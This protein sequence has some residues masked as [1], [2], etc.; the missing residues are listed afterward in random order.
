MQTSPEINE[1]AKALAK[2]QGEFP[3]IPKEKKVEV[4]SKPPERKFLYAYYYAELSTI[5]SHIKSVMAANGLS[6]VQGIVEN[7][8]GMACVTKLIHSSGQYFETTTPMILP[9][10]FDM[11]GLAGALT[12]ARRYAVMAI[13]GISPESDDDS[14]GS[15]DKEAVIMDKPRPMKTQEPTKEGPASKA[16]IVALYTACKGKGLNEAKLKEL[17]KEKFGTDDVYKITRSQVLTL[18]TFVQT[19]NQ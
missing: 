11:Q 10:K 16:E 7:P 2:A 13:L 9:E 3:E 5:F 8:Q 19:K 14:N 4:H 6:V 18:T 15:M 1:I 17:L 12:F